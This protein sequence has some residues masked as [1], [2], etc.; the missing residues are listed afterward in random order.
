MTTPLRAL[1]CC[2]ILAVAAPARADGADIKRKEAAEKLFNEGRE[3]LTRGEHELACA[4]FKGSADLF[5]VVNT[6][7]NVARCAER[8]G[9]V[10]EAMRVWREVIGLLAEGDERLAAARERVAALDARVP[11][12]TL[13]VD[14]R[15]PVA[16]RLSVD[17]SW[18][19]R[20]GWTAPI[21]LAPGEHRILVIDAPGRPERGFTVT[22]AEGERKTLAIGAVAAD[23]APPPPPPVP[24]PRATGRRTAGFVALGVGVAG[25]VAAGIT[26]GVLLSRDA[27]IHELCPGRVCPPEGWDLITG[28]K[29]IFIANAVA[30]GLGIAGAGAGAALLITSRRPE[31]P[32][33]ALAPWFG[34]GGAGAALAGRF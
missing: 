18:I 15:L 21:A 8:E 30:W 17:G 12:L 34:P 3:A 20:A 5:P 13:E 23:S 6:L 22:L 10:L 16:A 29:P 1:L 2:S 4:R 24:L 28:G 31:P 11:K 27:R 19:G 25:L 14:P 7:A 33:A 26:G 32:R 9:R